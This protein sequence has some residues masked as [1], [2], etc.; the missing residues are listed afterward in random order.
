MNDRWDST[1]CQSM[2][3]VGLRRVIDGPTATARMARLLAVLTI[4]LLSGCGAL[5][6][7]KGV[8]ASYL[9][10][11]YL[12]PS[13]DGLRPINP[14]LLTRSQPAEHRV[15]A[16]DVLTIYIPGVLGTASTDVH[17]I[18]ETPPINYPQDQEMPPTIGYPITVRDDGTISL[19]Q[20]PPISVRGLSLA[21]VEEA[22]RRA[23][24]KPKQVLPVGKERILVSLQRPRMYRVLVVREDSSFVTTTG[25][26]GVGQ[27]NLGNSR[28]GTARIVSLKA[29]EN[30]VLHAL[31]RTQG[32]DG[33]PGLDAEGAIYVIRRRSGG[34][35]GGPIGAPIGVDP[36]LPAP[37][38]WQTMTPTVSNPSP[39]GDGSTVIRFQ[40]PD[41]NYRSSR[42]DA[43]SGHSFGAAPSSIPT[44][45]RY[46]APLGAMTTSVPAPH[47]YGPTSGRY[48][49]PLGAVGTIPSAAHTP[50]MSGPSPTAG[51][52]YAIAPESGPVPAAPTN[53]DTIASPRQTAPMNSGRY[54]AP[55]FAASSPAPTMA[56]RPSASYRSAP[57]GTAPVRPVGNISV[58][59]PSAP[60][61]TAQFTTGPTPI[62]GQQPSPPQGW[63]G[64]QPN[65]AGGLPGVMPPA[66]ALTN[67][68]PIPAMT[69]QAGPLVSAGPTPG[70]PMATSIAPVD[71]IMLPSGGWSPGPMASLPTD[72]YFDTMLTAGLDSTI[73]GPNVIRI[74]VR[75]G[76]GE[77]VQIRESDITLEDGDIVFIEARGSEVFYTGGLLGGGQFTLPRDYD[78]RA[79]EALSIAQ[80]A[81]VGQGGGTRAIGGVSALNQD[82]TISAS[83]LIV[84]RK[85]ADGTSVP[86]EVDLN[87]AKQDMTGRENIIIQ[88]GDYLYLQYSCVEAIAAFFERHLLEGALFG[89]AAA[90]FQ[91]N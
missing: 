10:C 64:P 45:G 51:S 55:A 58:R 59:G 16:G 81:S 1:S 19:P 56:N 43:Y 90:Q 5:H 40:S 17:T 62:P 41:G 23:Y 63:A 76:P 18:G 7:I 78:L 35:F 13:R 36:G 33:L 53:W 65:A 47:T 50:M 89:V 72:D 38:N 85:L 70:L 86:I 80:S 74:P 11:E 4:G 27:V 2:C 73:D 20:V 91:S 30:D 82:V 39:Y 52:R 83:K 26:G 28:R 25:G 22:V 77:P 61:G 48:G 67:P 60:I 21:Q 84:V 29:Y 87:R 66:T 8:P 9:P 46:G 12:G 68:S 32:A 57:V 24:S 31:A 15:D 79:L 88:P 44:S 37:G 3:A 49:A 14:M 34:G 69:P 54:G 71:P 6:P 42:G 75:V